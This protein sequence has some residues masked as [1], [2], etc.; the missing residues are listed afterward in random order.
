MKL[1]VSFHQVQ[2]QVVPD[3]GTLRLQWEVSNKVSHVVVRAVSE[4]EVVQV[5]IPAIEYTSLFQRNKYYHLKGLKSLTDYTLYFDV[6][7]S[8]GARSQ[9]VKRV[10]T[11]EDITAPQDRLQQVEVKKISGGIRIS[12]DKE[13][14]QAGRTDIEQAMIRIKDSETNKVIKEVGVRDIGKGGE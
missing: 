6:R 10:R 1:L 2:V 14:V 12:W 8:N 9:V 13:S 5:S 3:D 7:S 11:K 4:R